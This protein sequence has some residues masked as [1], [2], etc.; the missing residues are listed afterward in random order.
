MPFPEPVRKLPYANLSGADVYVLDDGQNQV[1]F[2]E[3]P[4]DRAPVTVPTHT[5]GVEWGV[6]VEGEIEMTLGDRKERHPAGT[7][8]LIPAGLPH[9]FRFQSGTSSIHYFRERRLSPDR[10][11]PGG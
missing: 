4:A 11:R 3:V 1:L 9:S 6:V 8:H 10:L 7:T 5:H 2:M